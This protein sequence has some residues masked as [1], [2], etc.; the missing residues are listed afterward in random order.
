M[1]VVLILVDQ[2]REPSWLLNTFDIS[3]VRVSSEKS[4]FALCP[5]PFFIFC[6]LQYRDRR[7]FEHWSLWSCEKVG[8]V[9]TSDGVQQ[10]ETGKSY[11]KSVFGISP[12]FL[13]GCLP[14]DQIC[15]FLSSL[16]DALP[17][18]VDPNSVRASTV[19]LQPLQIAQNR[20]IS[21]LLL[22]SSHMDHRPVLRILR[23]LATT[24]SL[25]LPFPLPGMPF[26]MLSTWLAPARSWS[27]A[28]S[29][30]RLFLMSLPDALP[31]SADLYP[32]ASVVF[33]I[34]L[35]TIQLFCGLYL[36][37]CFPL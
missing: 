7:A 12:A 19:C 18:S 34:A 5:D 15:L 35:T 2:C 21:L 25:H 31:S 17:T 9:I 13:W 11:P 23:A 14:L 4:P 22:C 28:S 37:I 36:N 30:V 29:S 16:P 24:G 1:L 32:I 20:S 3:P 8:I 26:C 10:C 27:H 33:S 6:N